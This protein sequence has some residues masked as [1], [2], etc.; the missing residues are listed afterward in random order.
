MNTAQIFTKGSAFSLIFFLLIGLVSAQTPAGTLVKTIEYTFN[1]S[2]GTN[3]CAVAWN[4]D[5]RIYIT[6]I[7]GNESFPLEGFNTSAEMV[8]SA[9]AKFDYR[10]LWYNPATK[11][12]EGNGAGEAGWTAFSLNA[13]NTP[14]SN[15][16]LFVGQHQPDFQSVG[17]YNIDKKQVAFLNPDFTTIQLYSRERPKK[18]KKINLKWGDVSTFGL[19]SNSLGYTGA[20]GFEYVLLDYVAG[21]LIFFNTKGVISATRDIPE[22]APLND[23]FAFSFTN[24]HAFFYDKAAR[25]WYG[26]KVF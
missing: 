10:G 11:Q 4:P 12:M 20:K 8:F 1:Q 23:S 19:N 17:A 2:D 3:A 16:T 7:A 6:V 5:S 15:M 22:D 9:Q 18:I 26:Y 25:T 24:G 13:N 21:K 14:S